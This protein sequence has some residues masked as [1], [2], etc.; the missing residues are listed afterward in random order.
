MRITQEEIFGPLAAIQSFDTE[1]EAVDDANKCDVGLA[2]YLF[3]E[4]A[5]RI[6]RVVETLHY[7]MV[8]VNTGVISDAA[9]P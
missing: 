5:R 2:S 8:A 7:G 3:S 9:A 1:E 4:N 6:A